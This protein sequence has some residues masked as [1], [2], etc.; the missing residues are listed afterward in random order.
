MTN[1]A[2]ETVGVEAAQA[3]IERLNAN[4]GN[5]ESSRAIQA[6]MAEMDR[7]HAQ[8]LAAVRKAAELTQ[9]QLAHV[10]GVAQSE[11]SRIE[12]RQDLLL[13]TLA[14][15]LSAAG[16]RPRVVVTIGGVDVELDLTHYSAA[17]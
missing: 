1:P 5:T 9:I 13:S 15:Y 3:R 16:D 10:M 12:N 17:A 4:Y 7:V 6:E 11:I 2:R 14:S 8:N